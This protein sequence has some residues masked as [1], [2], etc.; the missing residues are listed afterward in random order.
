MITHIVAVARN[1]RQIN[2]PI[3]DIFDLDSRQIIRFINYFN[4]I[5]SYFL[6]NKYYNLI[7]CIDE[8]YF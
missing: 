2:S 7:Y 5:L 3:F 4:I 6:T 1:A 8:K